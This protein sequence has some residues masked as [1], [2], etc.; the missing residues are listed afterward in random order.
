MPGRLNKIWTRVGNRQ[1]LP[2]K[3]G[4]D[5]C[6]GWEIV[7]TEELGEKLKSGDVLTEAI[8]TDETLPPVAKHSEVSI[9]KFDECDADITVVLLRRQDA[10]KKVQ[11]LKRALETAQSVVTKMKTCSQNI[12]FW[13][14]EERL[15]IIV[16]E[17]F[18]WVDN[19][20]KLI[21]KEL[22]FDLLNLEKGNEKCFE[23]LDLGNVDLE[24]IVEQIDV[25]LQSLGLLNSRILNLHG[26]Q[27]FTF[28]N[29]LTKFS[30][31]IVKVNKTRF[32]SMKESPGYPNA[33]FLTHVL[34][35]EADILE[36]QKRTALSVLES[37]ILDQKEMHKPNLKCKN[38]LAISF[39]EENMKSCLIEANENWSNL[40]E[41]LND[42]PSRE[43]QEILILLAFL[44][45]SFKLSFKELLSFPSN[46]TGGTKEHYFSLE[47][48]F[49]KL[50]DFQLMTWIFHFLLTIEEHQTYF[51]K[52][53][54]NY[55][56]DKTLFY[57]E[58]YLLCKM[59]YVKKTLNELAEDIEAAKLIVLEK[60]KVME[61]LGEFFR[62][63]ILN[64][65]EIEM[66][67]MYEE[68]RKKWTVFIS[69]QNLIM[70]EV[71]V[72]QRFRAPVPVGFEDRVK[73]L[74]LQSQEICESLGKLTIQL[75]LIELSHREP[76]DNEL[77]RTLLTRIKTICTPSWLLD[78][79]EAVGQNR[80]MEQYRNRIEAYETELEALT[81]TIWSFLD[82][83]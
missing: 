70:L 63:R 49:E 18:N 65:Q 31:G 76:E 5:V 21:A 61:R 45:C 77:Q 26:N 80:E 52:S 55:F 64:E 66:K 2:N 79:A 1:F 82:Y 81:T 28:Q 23:F 40:G 73:E 69:K 50:I 27:F 9:S 25:S 44:T 12:R 34:R 56:Q 19:K 72:L 75:D 59:S 8:L 62:D 36:F 46:C 41:Y 11:Q 47:E 29:A 20:W 39:H 48:K 33:Y 6:D 15:K 3:T 4:S 43:F 60:E 67:T 37:V 24:E 35:I 57:T 14:L 54:R 51:P 53:L 83:E 10:A 13:E 16:S 78:Y 42:Y 71:G 38:K 7:D 32:R 30:G 74:S 68:V 17:E 22:Y 58:Q